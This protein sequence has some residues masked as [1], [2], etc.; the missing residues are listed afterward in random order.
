LLEVEI[1]A[2]VDYI[3]VNERF[4]VLGRDSTMVYS[5]EWDG[6]IL[7]S[8]SALSTAVR[9]AQWWEERGDFPFGIKV[10]EEAQ[11]KEDTYRSWL[12]RN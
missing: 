6:F 3:Y 5:N 10:A 4:E 7:G 1:P 12:A 9:V 8:G 2:N 11:I